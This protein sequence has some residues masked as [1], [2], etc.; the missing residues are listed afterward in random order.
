MRP[1]SMRLKTDH[2]PLLMSRIVGP[3][4]HSFAPYLDGRVGIRTRRALPNKRQK[5]ADELRARHVC[6]HGLSMN[7]SAWRA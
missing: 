4:L 3:P 7:S 5:T 1:V 2:Q 6:I